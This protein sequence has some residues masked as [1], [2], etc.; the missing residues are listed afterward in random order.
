M[1]PKTYTH[2][3][4]YECYLIA[5][6][7]SQEQ[8][9]QAIARILNRDPGTLCRELKRNAPRILTGYYL[10]HKAQARADGR[11]PG[12][13]RI[14]AMSFRDARSRVARKIVSPSSKASVSTRPWVS[15]H[16]T[17]TSTRSSASF[18]ASTQYDDTS[19]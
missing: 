1:T 8:S 7:N 4:I 9:L 17:T 15:T 13:D 5:V 16:P 11:V 10:A 12:Q 18:S 6:F 3:S 14:P 2:L 19:Q